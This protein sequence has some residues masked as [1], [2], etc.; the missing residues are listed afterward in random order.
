MP[1][2]QVTPKGQILIPKKIREK[3]CVNPGTKAIII[4]TPGGIV[5]RP[6]P[7]DPVKASC[8]FLEGTFSLTDDLIEEHKKESK[9]DEKNRT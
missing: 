6:A 8:G 4:E 9:T 5:I 3:Y 7:D 1:V 2:V